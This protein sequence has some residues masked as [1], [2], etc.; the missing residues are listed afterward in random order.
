MNDRDILTTV[1][2]IFRML[3]QH[4]QLKASSVCVGEKRRETIDNPKFQ[5]VYNPCHSIRSIQIV[6]YA[7]QNRLEDFEVSSLV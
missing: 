6:Y 5:T 7:T 1:I 2:F 3:Q 4:Q